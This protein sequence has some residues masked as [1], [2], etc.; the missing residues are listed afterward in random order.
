MS[1][2]LVR[3]RRVS[4]SHQASQQ[5]ACQHQWLSSLEHVMASVLKDA[6]L[7]VRPTT[8]GSNWYLV[9]TT[10]KPSMGRAPY[11][12]GLTAPLDDR[13]E[14]VPED[15]R[16]IALTDLGQARVIRQRLIQVVARYRR[17]LS[18][19]AATQASSA[20][21]SVVAM[22]RLHSNAACK[23]VCSIILF[24]HSTIPAETPSPSMCLPPFY[25]TRH[26]PLITSQVISLA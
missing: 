11:Q 10:L 14:E 12:A 22:A 19:S 7:E 17:T 15:S 21:K 26:G 24:V 1:H 4:V 5:G 9:L 18:R 8:V 23:E 3:A 16:A 6:V 25:R 20:R 13:L 2:L